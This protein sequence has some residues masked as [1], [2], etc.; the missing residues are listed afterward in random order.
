MNDDGM[1]DLCAAMYQFAGEVGAPE[2]LLDVL[3]AAQMGD[4]LPEDAIEVVL[5]VTAD[6]C[7]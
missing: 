7:E 2:R 4:P 5:S 3:L 6:E 1:R